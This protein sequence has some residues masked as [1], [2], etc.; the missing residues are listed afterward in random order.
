M[1]KIKQWLVHA[2]MMLVSLPGLTACKPK[3][4][5]S[6]LKK[7]YSKGRL[8]KMLGFTLI[9]CGCTGFARLLLVLI[10]VFLNALHLVR[11][12]VA[13]FRAAV[14]DTPGRGL[15]QAPPCKGNPDLLTC[16]P[17]LNVSIVIA[18]SLVW[19]CVSWGV[20]LTAPL[21][22]CRAGLSLH[23]RPCW[24]RVALGSGCPCHS[25]GIAG[26]MAAVCLIGL[27]QSLATLVWYLRLEGSSPACPGN[28]VFLLL[29]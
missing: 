18:F 27:V 14:Q 7:L 9:Q 3:G 19:V 4:S 8:D 25:C 11:V 22:R 23:T 15:V 2:P 24:S 26:T 10:S 12:A 5:T 13:A 17:V 16:Y 1:A 20:T 6:S 29:G 28:T 21:G